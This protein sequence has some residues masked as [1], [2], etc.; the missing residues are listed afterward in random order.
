MKYL[1]C[2]ISDN[3]KQTFDVQGIGGQV[4]TIPHEDVSLVVS[5]TDPI[6]FASIRKD[7]LVKYLLKHQATIEKIMHRHSVIPLKFGT[8]LEGEKE[9]EQVMKKGYEIFKRSLNTLKGKV[10]LDLV[11]GW[12]DLK[13]VI[14]EIAEMKEIRILKEEI[15][16]KPEEERVP[17]SI[18]L[19]KMVKDLLDKKKEKI[20]SAIL[21]A[22][23]D[24]A[25]AICRHA[26]LNDSMIF[27]MAFL[28]DRDKK[29]DFEQ[30]LDQLDKKLN[31]MV[32]FKLVGPLP[33]YSFNT[34]EVKKLASEEIAYAEALLG[35]I[36][37]STPQEVK[38]A[39][40]NMAQ[41]IHPDQNPNKPDAQKQFEELK[42]AFDLLYAYS[43]NGR[44]LFLIKE[45]SWQQPNMKF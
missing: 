7:D 2:V 22:F 43:K 17:G 39:Y 18:M 29:Q 6:P 19:G 9:T 33:P 37:E 34:L 10:E 41:K 25:R 12:S 42:K 31:G 5:D 24:K 4:Y 16:Q 15:N 40:R 28:V 21:S 44:D 36:E 1:Y 8:F 35:V 30:A 3:E 45:L 14:K 26:V 13:A 38:Q 20:A 27:N 32:N 23:K 11:A